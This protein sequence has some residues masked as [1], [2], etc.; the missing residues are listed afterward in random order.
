MRSPRRRAKPLD[1]IGDDGPP[2]L[3]LT[4]H[5]VQ[6]RRLTP[7]ARIQASIE[8]LAEIE[9]QAS[10]P[11]DAIAT[12][13]F[14]ARRFIGG[15]DR[16]DVSD[17]TYAALKAA[18]KL[19]WHLRRHNAK[20]DARGLVLVQLRLMEG[21]AADAVAGLFA[22]QRHA[23]EPLD[24]REK[25]LL[26]ALDGTVFDDPA[27][28]EALR[29]GVPEWLLPHLRARF[30]EALE[31]ELRALTAAAPVD[32]R[33]NLLKSDPVSAR[34][35]LAAE[36]L[37]AE[38]TRLSPIGLRL[39][40]R[41][42]VTAS[43]AF[44][45]GLVEI[46]DEGSQLVALL[47]GAR[48]G[49]RVCDYCA[50]A[51][52]KTLAL[53][54]AMGNSGRLVAADVSEARLEAAVKRLRRAGVGNVERRLLATGERWTKRA[55]E[56]FN[57]VLVD[58]PCTGTGTWRRH[59]GAA[60]RLVEQDLV[61]LLERQRRIL[62]DASRMV[63]AG[64]VLV[65]ATCSVLPDE[66]EGQVR[67][68]LREH[69]GPGE[70][71]GWERVTL[72]DAWRDAGLPGDPPGSGDALELTPLRHGTDGFFA[73]V[74]RRRLPGPVEPSAPAPIEAPQA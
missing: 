1:A 18:P 49:E 26:R 9:A 73:A 14:R 29:L 41:A 47:V 6:A 50:G 38:P 32:L 2:A 60:Q 57:R 64:G 71:G 33:V 48:P 56:G 4:V 43:Q 24:E 23:P 74:L 72:A 20:A 12:A 21:R 10:R 36:G 31:P 35:A 25:Q 45:D 28:P 40:G 17:R 55:R 59:A 15:G 11:P 5:G 27:M 30:G 53:A 62:S 44:R 16:R 67:T 42:P 69:D 70:H 65:Y 37:A 22:G 54:G 39:P 7:A 63:K 46:Q 19:R 66:N 52:G 58:A 34:A 61:E 3:R 8:L 13:W 68:F 51:G